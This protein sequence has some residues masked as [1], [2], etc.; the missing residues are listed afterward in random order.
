[1]RNNRKTVVFDLDSTL[2]DCTHRHHHVKCANPDFDTFHSLCNLDDVNEPVRFAL[3]CYAQK[4]YNVI[5]LTGRPIQYIDLTVDWLVDNMIEYDQ[6]LMKRDC[7]PR[8]D[9]DYKRH[10]ISKLIKQY[11]IVAVFED[12]KKIVDMFRDEFNLT[13]FDVAGN[14]Y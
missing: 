3:D 14:L 12:R 10:I 7:D 6:L 5:I 2:C 13:V 4:G 1:M 11:N 8:G 9:V